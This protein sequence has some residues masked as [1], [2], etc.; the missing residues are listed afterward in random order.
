MGAKAAPTVRHLSAGRSI[1]LLSVICILVACGG[2][3]ADRVREASEDTV[4]EDGSVSADIG[5]LEIEE[6]DCIVS[7]LDTGTSVEAGDDRAL[8]R[9]L[10]V[11]GDS[12]LR[13]C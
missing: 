11:P 7:G 4:V 1:L 12:C 3:D 10:A 9:C 8:F 13:C 2:S 5:V 6:G